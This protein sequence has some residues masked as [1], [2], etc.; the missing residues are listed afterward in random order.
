MDQPQGFAQEGKEHLVCKLKKALYGLKQSPRAWYQRIDAFF[1]KEGFSRS[2]ADHSLYVKQTSDHLIIVIIYVDDLI[3]LASKMSVLEW[4]K[5]KLAH[6]FEMSDL[7][8]LHYCLGVE[9]KRNRA[10]RTIT[11]SQRKYIEE[12]LKRFNMDDCKPIGTPLDVNSK[13]LKLTEEE[14]EEVHM[15]MQGIP[16]NPAVGSLMF[17][18]VATRVDLAFSMSVVSQ[19]MSKPGPSHWKAVK[20]IMRYLKGTL[21]LELCLGGNGITLRGYCDADWGGD[22]NERRSTTGYVFFVGDGAISWNCKRQPTIALSTTEAEYMAT[23]HCTKE[24][25][26]L[27][28]LLAD[29]GFTQE[30]ATSIMCDN[31][32]CIAL[33]K[34]PTNHSRTKHIDIQHHFIRERVESGEIGLTYCPTQDMVADVLTK[35]LAKDRHERLRSNMGLLG[36]DG[37]QSGSVEDIRNEDNKLVDNGCKQSMG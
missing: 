33:A 2:Q 12:V 31:Q 23:S 30:G 6:E 25:I 19:F 5:S 26:W 35:A 15:E 4:L 17:A 24:A 21:D 11:M 13:L 3:I 16:Y 28:K 22:V 34:N 1:T 27:R 18:M 20:R 29:V 32:G 9:F 37:L 8:E 7:G 14:F 10:R 36:I